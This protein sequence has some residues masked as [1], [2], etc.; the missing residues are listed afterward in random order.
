MTTSV[1]SF[2][3]GDVL[4]YYQDKYIFLLATIEFVYIAR[5]LS[6]SECKNWSALHN[7][8]LERGDLND[9][10]PTYWFVKLTSEEFKN[11]ITILANAQRDGN[12][13]K[14]LKKNTQKI[15]KDDL[16]ALRKEILEK[17]TWEELK[18]GIRNIK[19]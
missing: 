7:S 16:I 4:E 14:F 19:L 18:E 17:R 13:S 15:N 5:I 6:D 12:I 1:D 3:F 10:I 2:T 9:E 8:F 11:Q